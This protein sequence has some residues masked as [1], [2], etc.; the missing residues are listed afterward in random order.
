MSE[1]TSLE[2]WGGCL[3][4]HRGPRAGNAEGRDWLG[5]NGKEGFG[6]LV[7]DHFGQGGDR[8]PLS[9]TV[10]ERVAVEGEG[11]WARRTDCD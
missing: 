11:L 3:Q 8:V 10:D 4:T 9:P 1:D 7:Y 6:R 5:F 2:M